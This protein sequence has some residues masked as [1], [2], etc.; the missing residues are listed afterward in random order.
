MAVK[1]VLL[2]LGRLPTAV[3]LARSFK[4][5]GWRVVVC[6][7][8]RW[9]LARTSRCVDAVVQVPAP[10]TDQQGF[11]EALLAAID[12]WSVDLVVPV[13]EET[14]F[15]A[16]LM[17]RLPPGVQ[18]FCREQ[19]HVLQLHSKLQ[20]ARL[21]DS[22]GLAVPQTVAMTSAAAADLLAAHPCVI[23]PE[24]SCAGRG[25]HF[26][27][28]Q[29][30]LPTVD[31]RDSLVQRRIAGEEF[32]AFAIARHG[33]VLGIVIYR[34]MV[35]LNQVAVAFERV[36]QPSIAEWVTHFIAA[37]SHHGL[38]SFDF[39]VDSDGQAH[40]IECN[41]R[42]TSGLH[43]FTRESLGASIATGSTPELRDERQLQEFWSTWTHWFVSLG[44][45]AERRR[46]GRAIRQCRDV[47][48]RLRDPGVFLLATFSTW[49]IISRARRN[50]FDFASAAAKDI[51]WQSGYGD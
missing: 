10:A 40:A 20:F 36:E 28:P 45:P 21:A 27:T 3:D 8:F 1:T 6:D 38:V 19:Q 2:T 43:F 51:E 13:S 41:P 25:I 32:S 50:R 16:A 22:V 37:V 23:K 35:R 9:H 15:V 47:T 14:M 18:L 26:T 7:P 24:F 31:D 30:A 42:A 48:W 33:E 46:T 49:P 5:A 11:L 17:Q 34:S 29:H 44:A 12:T 4:A 39:I